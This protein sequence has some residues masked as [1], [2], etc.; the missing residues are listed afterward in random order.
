MG[1]ADLDPICSHIPFSQAIH[2]LPPP[3][4]GSERAN[5][6]YVALSVWSPVHKINPFSF[7][8]SLPRQVFWTRQWTHWNFKRY[9]MCMVHDRL[10]ETLSQSWFYILLL[11]T[12]SPSCK[13]HKCISKTNVNGFL[14]KDLYSLLPSTFH[15]YVPESVPSINRCSFHVSML[16]YSEWYAFSC[17][18][19]WSETELHFTTSDKHS[20]LI[21]KLASGQ[22]PV[23]GR[24]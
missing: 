14:N 4:C 19:S 23:W 20:L 11:G 3:L 18:Q 7:P 5:L 8:E 22:D 15:F 21:E 17:L 13:T 16:R 2:P 9:A 12:F 1:E 6:I 10:A 24:S